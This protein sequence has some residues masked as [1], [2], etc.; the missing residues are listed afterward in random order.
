MT[1]TIGK[2]A[3]RLLS[4]VVPKTTASAV[5]QTK[6]QWCTSTYSR[7][8]YRDCYGG[9]CEAWWCDSCNTC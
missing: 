1:R 4:V 3:D 7:R 9:Q 6:C 8:C 5:T 2:L